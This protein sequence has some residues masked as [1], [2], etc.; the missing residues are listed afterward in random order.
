L[1]SASLIV[2]AGQTGE[3]AT[4]MPVSIEPPDRTSHGWMVDVDVRDWSTFRHPLLAP[5]V[6]PGG[7]QSTFDQRIGRGGPAYFGLGGFIQ[8]G[9]GIE[10]ALSRRHLAPAAVLDTLGGVLASEGWRTARSDKGAYTNRTTQLFGGVEK[11]VSALRRPEVRALLDA[12]LADAHAEQAHGWFLKD[13]RRWYLSLEEAA[14]VVDGDPGDVFNELSELGVLTRG[15]ALKCVECRATSFY[16]LSERQR[17]T[18]RR[19]R[20]EQEA[21][22]SSWLKGPEP[23]FRYELHES[24]FQFLT[25]DCDLPLLASFDYF[26]TELAGDDQRPLDLGFEIDVFSP[27]GTKSEHDVVAVW[28]SDLWLGEATTKAWLEESA[29]EDLGR[30]E[31]LKLVADLLAA[32]GV[33]FAS[34]DRFREKTRGRINWTF[35]A[36]PTSEV[37]FREQ[38]QRRPVSDG[39]RP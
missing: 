28:G 9:L 3:L 25:H 29:E 27:D 36:W 1:R 14:A 21:T 37:I 11:A 18:C 10:N 4:P 35:R 12:Y 33:L 34:T 32:R 5:R 6:L 24:I 13:S 39:Q 30:I 17:F 2:T 38:I 16:L 19:C 20:R 22:R 26:A 8:A 23:Q 15:H 7:F 31:R